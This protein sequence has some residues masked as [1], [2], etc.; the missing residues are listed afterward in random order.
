MK[1]K[2]VYISF[3]LSMFLLPTSVSAQGLKESAWRLLAKLTYTRKE[4][5]ILGFKVDVPVYG[6]EVK[7]MEGKEIT[8]RGYII[9]TDGYKSTSAFI[10]SA[11]PYNMCFFCGGAGPETV[12]EVV[13]KTPIPYSADPV[14]LKGTLQLN[15]GDVNTLLYTL[16]NAVKAN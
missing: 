4:D 1:K 8:I 2:F 5:P 14:T 10:L 11:F 13:C 6:K 7:A 9:P 3:F 15:G 16:K 12:I